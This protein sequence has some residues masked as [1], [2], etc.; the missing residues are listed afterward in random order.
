MFNEGHVLSQQIRQLVRYLKDEFPFS[1]QVTIVDNASTDNTVEIA[2]ALSIE[3]QGVECI[4]LDRNGRGGAIREGWMRS[5]ATICCFMDVDMSTGLDAL[6][7]LVAPL[8][9]G[10]SDIAIGSRLSPTSAVARGPKREV[11]SRIYNFLIHILFGVRFRDAQC[12]FKAIRAD[13]AK[14]LLPYVKDNEWF[15]DTELLLIAEHNGLRI[16]ELAV[17]WIDD[18]DSRVN[19]RSTALADL[20]GLRRVAETMIRSRDRIQLP[21]NERRPLNDDFGRQLVSFIKIG[22]VATSISVILFATLLNLMHPVFANILT[23]MVTTPVNMWCNRQFTFGHRTRSDR[24]HQILTASIVFFAL[25]IISS[26][27][28]MISSTPNHTRSLLIA[29]SCWTLSSVVRFA[30]LRN[31][32]FKSAVDY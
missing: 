22:V 13:I 29:T 20:G 24:N 1:W 27:L 31:W 4:E 17:D 9:T 28:L 2:R 23:L 18:P 21:H 16:H 10:H 14:D 15:F 26:L 25:V 32:V 6:L 5:A 11:I 3:I 8:I 30:L 19:I 7:P 12:G